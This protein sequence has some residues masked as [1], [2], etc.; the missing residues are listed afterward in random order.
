VTDTG[1]RELLTMKLSG[2]DRSEPIALSTGRGGVLV[3]GADPVEFSFGG[4]D[5]VITDD[6]KAFL[7]KMRKYLTPFQHLSLRPKS[8]DYAP[9]SPR[10]TQGD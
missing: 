4:P 5:I 7:E 1:D 8:F 6:D 3:R 9:K 2:A 10:Q